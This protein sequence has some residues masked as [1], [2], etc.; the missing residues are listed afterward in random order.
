MFKKNTVAP[1]QKE[2]L[3]SKIKTKSEIYIQSFHTWKVL[4][5]SVRHKHYVCK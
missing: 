2:T 5:S 1:N 3:L 4:R